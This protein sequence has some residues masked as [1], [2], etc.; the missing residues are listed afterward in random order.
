MP[1]FVTNTL[2]WCSTHIIDIVI[3]SV[4][5]LV[6]YGIAFA[7]LSFL[8]ASYC[9]YV[10]TLRRGKP[11]KWAREPQT[12]DPLMMKM[13]EEG[14]TWLEQHIHQRTEVQIENGGLRLCGEYFDLG[15]D[16]CV[17]VLSGRSESL[18]YGYYFGQPYAAVG[19]NV[20]VIDPR[21]HGW[22]EGTY[23]T[24]GFEES[25]DAL[26]W[27]K[28]VH[29]TFGVRSIVLHGICIG[30]AA[31]LFA[32][33][34]DECP[35]YIDG[36]VADG[37]FANF[38]ESLKNHLIEFKKPTFPIANLINM[39]S[40]HYT[41]HNLKYGPI[42]VIHKLDRPI[43]M[44]FSKEDM[45]SVPEFSQ[46]LYDKVSHDKKELVWFEHGAHSML[47]VNDDERY[48]AAIQA[49]LACH[50]PSVPSQNL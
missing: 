13:Y 41:G 44:L 22:S 45:Y 37:M 17:I 9:V 14:N 36:F 21:A 11:E 23:N 27:A 34:S 46:K 29:D 25:K 20:L 50:L 47:R 28:Y 10:S 35:D 6:I 39:W 40:K 31:G 38:N 19:Y 43:L 42:D 7:I 3:W 15:N 16:K 33:T 8:I 30:A 32:L 4:I 18:R 12:T 48:D 5:G 2:E 1:P 26:A 49:F 24:V